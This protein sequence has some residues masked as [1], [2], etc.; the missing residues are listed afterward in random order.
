MIENLSSTI[1]SLRFY[2][3]L[4]ALLHVDLGFWALFVD[5]ENRQLNLSL[6]TFFF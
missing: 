6:N 2:L 4:I 5:A 3:G 1:G